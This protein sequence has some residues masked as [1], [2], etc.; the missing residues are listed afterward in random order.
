MSDVSQQHQQAYREGCEYYEQGDLEQA[1]QSFRKA[2]ELS[3]EDAQSWFALGN[4]YD[5]VKKP[6]QAEICF[7]K[8]LEL[9]APSA[10][11][12]VNFNLGNSLLDQGKLSEAIECYA[13][14]EA[15]SVAYEP[16]QKNMLLAKRALQ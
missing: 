2:L 8:S 4:C 3:P 10:E 14:V 15:A 9:S 11:S 13:K 6:L 5:S 1:K 12:Q 16:A 7:R